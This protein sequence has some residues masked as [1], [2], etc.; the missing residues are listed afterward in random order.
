MQP[1]SDSPQAA[2]VTSARN[3]RS[4]ILAVAFGALA[5]G[6]FYYFDVMPRVD[7]KKALAQTPKDT[8]PSVVVVPAQRGQA[9]T[10]LALPGTLLPI[11]E[12]PIY[13]RTNGYV[14]HWH[15][16]IG[17]KVQMGQ[18]LAEID[19][20]ELDREIKQANAEAQQARANLNIARSTHQR[21]Q[22]LLDKGAVSRQAVD[23]KASEYEARRADYAAEQANVARL[24]ELKSFQR[25]S[26]PF[27][28]IITGRQI[29]IGQL[30]AAGNTDPN[31]WL[32]KLAKTDTLRM[33]VSVPQSHARMVQTDVPVTVALREFQGKAFAAKVMRTA[34]ALDAQSKTLTTEVHIPNTDGALLAGMY[35]QVKFALT[36]S[37]PSILIPANT[38]IVRADGPQVAAVANDVVSMRKVT[39]GRDLGTQ[40]EVLAGLNDKEM[41]IT[42]PTDAMREG[43]AVKSVQ[44]PSPDKAAD[45]PTDKPATKADGAPQPNA[46]GKVA[47]KK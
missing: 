40:I 18:L 8:R 4:A 44:P 1:T 24:R 38:L 21:W 11:Q 6:A 47:E 2:T 5:L 45:K 30:I 28:G 43:V 25:V 34:G 32:F 10:E 29:E 13:A 22:S 37:E 14:K 23:E 42:N 9:N 39:L 19:T 36:Q 41:I 33:Y 20:P 26:A 17:T 27:S 3:P 16:D 12:T 35:A 7:A 15:T 46:S 31:R